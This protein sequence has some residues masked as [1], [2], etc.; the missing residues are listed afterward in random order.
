[1]ASNRRR[2]S[3]ALSAEEARRFRLQDA[4]LA[5]STHE[6]AARLQPRS[7]ELTRS[8]IDLDV[9]GDK[10]VAAPNK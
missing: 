5:R 10:K 8:T 3:R 7:E 6:F 1:M 9:R 4:V 2:T